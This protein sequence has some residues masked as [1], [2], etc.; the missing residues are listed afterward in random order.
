MPSAPFCLQGSNGLGTLYI[1]CACGREGGRA[2]GRADGCMDAW[3]RGCV[4]AGAGGC[5]RVRAYVRVC[6]CVWVGGWAG[7]RVR[8][9]HMVADFWRLGKRLG[10]MGS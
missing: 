10:G 9:S 2:G 7:G 4:R 5:L 3:V 6:V 1:V 8:V